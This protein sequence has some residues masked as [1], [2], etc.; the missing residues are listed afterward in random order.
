[1]SCCLT[2]TAHS[3]SAGNQEK[4][5][6][7]PTQ[8]PALPFPPALRWWQRWGEG[9]WGTAQSCRALA[10]GHRVL[11]V[12][13]EL[14]QGSGATE[15]GQG[16]PLGSQPARAG[17]RLGCSSF[18]SLGCDVGQDAAEP[19]SPYPSRIHP[20]S[21]P[22][23]QPE[24]CRRG[25]TFIPRVPVGE[26]AQLI[27]PVAVYTPGVVWNACGG[28][29]LE[30]RAPSWLLLPC[31]HLIIEE[32]AAGKLIHPKSRLSVSWAGPSSSPTLGVG[33][34]LHWSDSFP[35]FP[36]GCGSCPSP[37]LLLSSQP[38]KPQTL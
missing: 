26:E 38:D 37:A 25:S 6:E 3:T 33:W 23:G 16:A 18:Q 12:T 10:S 13:Q 35:A 4:S 1:M 27:P 29:M 9:W 7:P 24:G 32:S 17:A 28:G 36:R 22:G 11:Q 30:L 8:L 20:Q 21:S 19:S 14:G 2:D 15:Q 34:T 5:L 31:C